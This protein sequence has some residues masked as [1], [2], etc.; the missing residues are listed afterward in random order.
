M[1][2]RN[3]TVYYKILWVSFFFLLHFVCKAF[4]YDNPNLFSV[5]GA[6]GV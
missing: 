5:P 3:I 6:N 1:S 4:H 2:I